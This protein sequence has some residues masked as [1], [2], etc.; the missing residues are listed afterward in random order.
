M[1]DVL[2]KRSSVK[3][4]SALALIFLIVMFVLPLLQGNIFELDI[5]CVITFIINGAFFVIGTY[6]TINKYILSIEMIYWIFMFVFMY[7]APMIQY[8]NGEFPWNGQIQT[9]EILF[10]NFIILLF[11]TFFLI[12]KQAFKH[13]RIKHVLKSDG[14]IFMCQTFEYS[15]KLK[16]IAT[17][18]MCILTVYSV[19]RTGLLGIITSR[20]SAVKAF[21]SGNNSAIELIV[22]SIIPAFMA[23]TVAEAAQCFITKKENGIRFVIVSICLLACFFPTTLPRYKMAVI[24]GTIFLVLFP[25]VKKGKRF[26]WLFAIAMFLAFPL[27]GGARRVLELNSFKAVFDEGLLNV[28]LKGDYDAYR[29]L[30][31]S[32]RFVKQEGIVYGYQL[33]GT[34]LF[35]I[36]RSIWPSKPIGSGAM[37]IQNEFGKGVFSN[38]S[39]PFVSEGFINFGLLGVVLFGIWLGYFASKLDKKYWKYNA[40]SKGFSFSPYIF[41]VFMVFFMLRGDLLSSYA[42]ILGFLVTGYLLRFLSKHL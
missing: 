23:Y 14:S 16:I 18:L 40:T 27:L 30:V 37:S 24:Y 35:F 19:Y 15:S 6:L 38:V 17:V 34:L 1:E 13:L 42:Y 20:D 39:C 10:A 4:N 28:Y 25:W 7:F 41:I 21:Y 2:K 36:P 32:L 3:V 5:L 9:N 11:S 33:L 31:S 22:E 29:M 26:F 12:G 8:Q